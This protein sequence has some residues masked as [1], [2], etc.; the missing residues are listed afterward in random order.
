MLERMIES[1]LRECESE[2]EFDVSL[3]ELRSF[4]DM[5]ETEI[6]YDKGWG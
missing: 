4:L 3:N 1:M 5:L 2:E 6:A